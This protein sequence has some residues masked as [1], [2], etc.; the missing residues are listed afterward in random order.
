MPGRVPEYDHLI[1]SP[2][3]PF[4]DSYHASKSRA[5]V[6]QP[7]IV[8]RNPGDEDALGLATD[9]GKAEES[10]TVTSDVLEDVRGATAI[11]LKIVE[12]NA[13]EGSAGGLL[14]CDHDEPVAIAHRQGSQ[15]DG[16]DHAENSGVYSDTQCRA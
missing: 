7:K 11:V 4:V 13:A 16:V 5:N 2:R 12:R 8:A 1:D 9:W 15:D 10:D 14:A 3:R 6:E